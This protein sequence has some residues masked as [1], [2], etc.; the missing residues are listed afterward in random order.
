[1]GTLRYRSLRSCL[2]Q[3][4]KLDLGKY[5]EW[6]Y[7]LNFFMSLRLWG[8]GG[9]NPIRG[10]DKQLGDDG[11]DDRA[12]GNVMPCEW[13]IWN[14]VVAVSVTSH[15]LFFTELCIS[16]TFCASFHAGSSL[17][18]VFSRMLCVGSVILRF[19]PENYNFYDF[20]SDVNRGQI[21]TFWGKKMLHGDHCIYILE[22]TH[23]TSPVWVCLQ[24][25]IWIIIKKIQR[26]IFNWL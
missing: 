8:T 9:T 4:E 3:F 14:V 20:S 13:R 23:I 19:K 26:L 7:Q 5:L 22:W 18:D 6:N 16:A 24:T 15:S 12:M 10:A 21:W 17:P 2:D 25:S 1:V 11:D